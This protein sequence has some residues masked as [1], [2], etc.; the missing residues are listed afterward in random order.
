M[1]CSVSVFDNP[2]VR[3]VALFSALLAIGLVTRFPAWQFPHLYALHGVL[4]A[5]FF[6]ALALWHFNRD[7]TVAQLVVAT[8]AMAVSL[9]VMSEVMGLSFLFLATSTLVVCM[10]LRNVAPERKR[11]VCAVAFGMFDYPCALLAG[12]LVGSYVF[13]FGVLPT[14]ALLFAVALT[15]SLFASLLMTKPKS[16]R[17]TVA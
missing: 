15:L 1:K 5:P 17:G 12:I 2:V 16:E 11:F 10:A 8:L 9:N 7:G 13:S 4:A 14:M 6:S 3:T